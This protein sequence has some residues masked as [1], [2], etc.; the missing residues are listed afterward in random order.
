VPRLVDVIGWV[1]GRTR[2][3]RY[4]CEPLVA[5]C[6]LLRRL[7][8]PCRWADLEVV[9]G[10]HASALSENYWE[11]S[12]TLIE[13]R[14]KL[15]TNFQRELLRSRAEFY[16]KAI[17][18]RVAPLD[19]CVGF[20]D[21]TKIAMAR[22]GGRTSNQRAVYSGHKRF[23]CFSYQSITTPDGLLFNIYG[24]E[25]GRRHDM[26]LY[27][28]SGIDEELSV[29]ILVDRKQFCI[30][31][32]AAYVLRPFLQVGFPTVNADPE[33]SIYNAKMSSVRIAVEWTYKD[34]KKKLDQHRLQAETES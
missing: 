3:N 24:P 32:D 17:Q 7:A 26:T 19:S 29:A 8:S 13:R 25:D 20:I 23:H 18:N 31:G 16:S 10:K 6:I 11:V 2:R 5:I 9:F 34:I 30:Y 14:G 33:T 4:R 27:N 21:C 12:E 15:I 28:K 22:P 1:S